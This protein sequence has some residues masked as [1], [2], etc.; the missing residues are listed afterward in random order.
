MVNKNIF[1]YILI[2]I[3]IISCSKHLGFDYKQNVINIKGEPLNINQLVGKPN[4]IICIDTLLVY[5]DVYDEKTLSVFDLKNNSFI[6]RFVSQGQGP[7]EVFPSRFFFLQYPQKDKLD[8]YQSSAA[9]LTTIDVPDFRISNKIKIVS[10]TTQQRPPSEMQRAKNYYIGTGMFEGGRFSIYNSDLEYL[11]TDAS[12]PFNGND[13]EPS[14]TF[15]TYQGKFCTNPDKNYFAMGCWFSDHIAFYEV[16]GNNI[17]TLRKYSSSDV[18]VDVRSTNGRTGM[19]PKSESKIS[20]TASFGTASYCYMLFTGKTYAENNEKTTGGHYIIVFDWQGNYIKTYN[21][22]YEIHSFCV[23]ENSNCIYAT[24]LDE[25]LDY[26]I[27]KLNINDSNLSNP[28]SAKTTVRQNNT[29]PT[30]TISRQYN[31]PAKVQIL[32]LDGKV[33]PSDSMLDYEK[34]KEMRT[35]RSEDGDTVF[36]YITTK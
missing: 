33:I 23:D 3:S 24:A 32:I 6:G 8:I 22:D 7:E 35:E 36:A 28:Q 27:I 16:T 2:A 14:E 20:Y 25:N 19:R 29:Q 13:M 21:T 1:L 5:I 15:F 26:I 12:Y 31:F 18:N 17:I 10:A 34:V 30:E 9:I 4:E 11:Y